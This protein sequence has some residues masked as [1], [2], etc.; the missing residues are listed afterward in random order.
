MLDA[1]PT[2]FISHSSKYK[3]QVAVPFRDHIEAL[4]MKA[5]LV[6]E[7]PHPAEAG[8]EPEAKVEYFLQGADM[9]VALLTP[10]DRIEGGEIR[11]R[12][13]IADE[14]GR[15]RSLPHLRHRIQVFKAPDVA[16]HSN[17]NPTRE[18]LDITN[19]A[20]SFAA[21]E[22][23]AV[24]WGV[25]SRPDEEA[26]TVAA[27]PIGPAE[28]EQPEGNRS[29]DAAE[30]AGAALAE[31]RAIVLDLDQDPS[32][33]RSL[34][35][36]RAH[37]A[38][39]TAL[40][41]LASNSIYGVHELNGLHRI[42]AELRLSAEEIRHL[43][44]SVVRHLDL[45]TGPGWYWLRSASAAECHEMLIEL[46]AAD[47]DASVRAKSMGLLAKARRELAPRWVKALVKSGLDSEDGQIRRAAL[48]L[49]AAKGKVRFLS[50]ISS[51]PGSGFD[52]AVLEVRARE[53]PSAALRTLV[54]NPYNH[55]ETIEESLLASPKKLPASTLR[56]GL[57]APFFRTRI[58]CLRGLERSR[59]LRRTDLDALLSDDNSKVRDEALRVASRKGWRVDQ[60]IADEIVSGTDL[61]FFA[62]S[63]LQLAYLSTLERDQLDKRLKWIGGD[64]WNVYAALGLSGGEEE[65]E[66]ARADLDSEF[67]AMRASYRTEVRQ[68]IERDQLK[69]NQELALR[70]NKTRLTKLI[71]HEMAIFFDGHERLD[72]FTLKRFQAVALRI[73]TK[74]G[75]PSDA[76]YA[77]SLLFS[78][79]HDIVF[80]AIKLL[81]RFGGP[82][83]AA[84]VVDA[85][86]QLY[87]EH[88]AKGAR[89]GA[90]LAEDKAA[91]GTLMLES[92]DDELRL[93]AIKTLEHAPIKE[94][95]R[96]LLPLLKD[97]SDSIRAAA[98]DQLAKRLNR[99]QRRKLLDVYPKGGYYYYNVIA[100]L[101]RDLYAPGWLRT[102][103]EDT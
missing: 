69:E 79:E 89:I 40:T 10:D 49:L 46:A 67:S 48:E 45:D 47:P 88:S 75:K 92:D 62:T 91:I 33:S 1:K 101:D 78:N 77:R 90:A 96:A 57:S 28:G 98:I 26:S 97:G 80:A 44:R 74:I 59:H 81:D 25:M 12:A 39:S 37:I 52:K 100:R 38:A 102:A 56:S 30:Q 70:K 51:D 19:P 14:I 94:A 55:S 84:K 103:L 72:S 68:A 82:E 58:L 64:G 3:D 2:I 35:I 83:D 8:S 53:T 63:E 95:E 36:R 42:R 27:G 11:A 24:E 73:L 87:F 18:T 50:Q 60:E 16:V 31:L 41:S 99:T 22:R 21:F 76:A 20:A 65:A 9:F 15:A 85:S 66:R 13:N 7:M 5:V 61:D 6:E 32:I 29:D 71:D 43:L 93:I 34:A 23:Q 54:V 4:G 86:G 17:I